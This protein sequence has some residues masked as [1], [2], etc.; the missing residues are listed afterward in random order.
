[1]CRDN[2]DLY[3]VCNH[4]MWILVTFLGAVPEISTVSL[5]FCFLN[6]RRIPSNASQ[7]VPFRPLPF[8]ILFH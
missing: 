7:P 3:L 2:S 1:M 5:V 8:I 6:A 4:V